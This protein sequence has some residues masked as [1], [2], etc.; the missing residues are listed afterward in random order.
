MAAI[1]ELRG[2]LAQRPSPPGANRASRSRAQASKNISSPLTKKAKKTRT[3]SPALDADLEDDLAG[4]FEW[5]AEELDV[6]GDLHDQRRQPTALAAL[7]Q[8]VDCH[9]EPA[10]QNSRDQLPPQG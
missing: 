4:D 3:T 10:G 1:E 8:T 6:P 5:E 9:W 2:H 7:R